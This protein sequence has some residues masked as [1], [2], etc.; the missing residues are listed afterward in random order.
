CCLNEI[1]QFVNLSALPSHAVMAVKNAM[2]LFL[3]NVATSSSLYIILVDDFLDPNINDLKIKTDFIVVKTSGQSLWVSS[4]FSNDEIGLFNQ[5]QKLILDNQ[6]VRKWLMKKWP[7]RTH[8]Y[9]FKADSMLNDEQCQELVN[10]LVSQYRNQQHQLAIYDVDTRDAQLHCFPPKI[11]ESKTLLARFNVPLRLESCLSHFRKDGGSRSIHADFTVSKLM[12][13]VSPVTGVINHLDLFNVTKNT[14]IKIYRTG[15]F[16]SPISTELAEFDQNSFVQ[17][18]LGKGV[19]REQ[20]QASALCEAIERSNAQFKGDEPLYKARPVELTKRHVSFQDLTPY[21]IKQY[22]RFADSNDSEAER[23]QAS[24]PYKNEPIH[25]LATWSLTNDEHV[26]VP[27]TC[28]FSNIE[29]PQ[30]QTTTQRFDD[31]K[32]GRWHSNGAAA[33]N[34]LEE[35]ILQGLYELIERDAT[36]I[37]WY[38]Q[39]ERPAFDLSRIDRDFYVPLEQT[40][41]KTYHF[42]VLDVTHDLGVPAMVAVGRH[43][44]NGGYIFG[45]GCHLQPELAAQRAL[46]ELCQLIPIRNQQGAPFI[47]DEIEDGAYLHPNDALEAEVPFTTS[48]DDMKEDILAIVEKLSNVQLETLVLDYSR[49]PIP[50]HTVKVFVPGFCHIWPQLANERLYQVPLK[51]KWLNEAKNEN[52]INPLGL[53]I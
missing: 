46:T 35:A 36:A 53:Y 42:W 49:A 51:L 23:V 43:K 45:F 6:P 22:R 32:F 16:K 47:F 19:S 13:F 27:L 11:D 25:W 1:C 24:I 38:N 28:C 3:N 30:K 26:Y 18:C 17:I 50:L 52:S 33:G 8:S 15:F 7:E 9:A 39:I 14:A 2:R 5:F 21:S 41:S 40:L 37:W 12:P 31:E 4:K 34:T 29:I 10:M 20:S 48:S 44:E